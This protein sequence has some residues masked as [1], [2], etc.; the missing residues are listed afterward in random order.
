MPKEASRKITKAK[1]IVAKKAHSRQRQKE[2]ATT[3]I[4]KVLVTLLEFWA[5][6]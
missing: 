4:T 6:K 2:M 1:K 3:S 5:S